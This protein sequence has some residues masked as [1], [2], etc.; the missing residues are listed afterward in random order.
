MTAVLMAALLVA[1]AGIGVGVGWAWGAFIE[2]HPLPEVEVR[3]INRTV[4]VLGDKR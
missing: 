3:P 2:R 4:R 1:A